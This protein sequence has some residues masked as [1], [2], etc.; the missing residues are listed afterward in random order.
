VVILP[1]D[2]S[3]RW[4]ASPVPSG[5]A[6]RLAPDPPPPARLNAPRLAPDPPPPARLNAPRLEPMQTTP[7]PVS[8]PVELHA[9]WA[10]PDSPSDTK[11]AR[12]LPTSSTFFTDR[13]SPDHQCQLETD[14]FLCLLESFIYYLSFRI[15]GAKQSPDCARDGFWSFVL[16]TSGRIQLQTVIF[17]W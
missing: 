5:T 4:F 9:A 15:V 13:R 12:Q 1:A 2:V 11:T 10:V 14:F 7:T 17:A 8:G 3:L 16:E 6:P